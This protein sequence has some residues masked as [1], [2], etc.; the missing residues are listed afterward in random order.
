MVF[1]SMLICGSFIDLDHMEIP[2]RFSIGLAVVGVALSTLVPS[3]HIST[4]GPLVAASIQSSFESILGVLVGSGLILW[5]GLLAEVALK[6]E[7]MGFGD[8]KLLG[9][10]GAFLGW[11]GA[12]FSIFGGAVVGCLG[13]VTWMIFNRKKKGKDSEDLIGRQIPFG[14]MLSAG[15][16]IYA[17]LLESHVDK[18]FEDVS[19]IFQQTLR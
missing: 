11:Q 8:V 12:I 19:V 14:P 10:V 7:A 6:K 2:N 17:L 5:I 4:E 16:L 18:Y 15:A 3:L 1:A 13:V 9:G